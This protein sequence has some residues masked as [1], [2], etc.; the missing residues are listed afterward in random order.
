MTESR[1]RILFVLNEPGYFRMY[2]ST[3]VE[4]SRRGWE[5]L[6]AFDDPD[7]RGGSVPRGAGVRVQSLGAL[8]DGVS[9]TLLK[10]RAALDYLRYLEPAF[11]HARYLRRRS[12]RH[13]PASCRFLT[14]VRG[15]PRW[16]V[17]LL[18]GAHRI[19]ERAAPARAGVVDFV[20]RA[21]PDAIF[22][23]PL[24]IIGEKGARETEVVKAGRSLGIPVIVGVA[25]WDHLT[26]KG[27]IRVVPDA[28]TVWNDVQRREAS[29]LHRIPRSRII[30]TGAQALDHWFEPIRGDAARFRQRLGIA[31][32]RRVLLFVGSSRRMAAGDSEVAF[33]R[34][35][36]DTIRASHNKEVRDAFILIRPHP[37]N[38]EA[39]E[40]ASLREPDVAVYPGSYSGIPL[41]DEEIETFR[42]S[43]LASSA[44]I[45]VN[46][47]AM[48]E[49]AILRRPV[50]TVRDPAFAHSQ[51]QTLHFAYLARDR[52][53]FASVADTLEGHRTQ[54]EELFAGRGQRPEDADRFVERFV[55]PLGL[56]E[57]ATQ[58]LCDAIE[59]VG[60]RGVVARRA[61]ASEAPAAV[62]DEP[63]VAARQVRSGRR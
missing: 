15:L 59:S 63:G 55:R 1:R 19:A 2:G 22:V 26:S 11:A 5:V 14:R 51:R 45:G 9:L 58:H 12:A 50:F 31:D 46:T 3:I 57:A 41:T 18:I 52:G 10:A 43:L 53:G 29:E 44:V 23:S 54:L 13:L 62:L 28:V 38:T 7:K 4:L 24:V 47:T 42:Q 37:S 56:Q 36:I 35:W 33:A 17:S 8:P 21:R 6:L 61:A 16:M 60:K 34:R 40:R 27:L 25:S 49:A 20:R 30:I 39:W 32:D 48:I